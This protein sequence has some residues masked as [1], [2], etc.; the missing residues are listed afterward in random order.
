MSLVRP[1]SVDIDVFTWDP[2]AYIGLPDAFINMYVRASFLGDASTIDCQTPV[3]YREDCDDRHLIAKL[4]YGK[5]WT[6]GTMSARNA[7]YISRWLFCSPCEHLNPHQIPDDHIHVRIHVDPCIP[8]DTRTKAL[9]RT[10][11]IHC[12]ARRRIILYNNI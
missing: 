4:V 3:K 2:F 8:T 5:T 9:M 12:L 6:H 1:E 7:T 10:S 11:T